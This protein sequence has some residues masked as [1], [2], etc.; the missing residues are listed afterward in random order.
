MAGVLRILRKKHPPQEG[1]LDLWEDADSG[2]PEVEDAEQ[3]L[4]RLKSKA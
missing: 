1:I 3:R 4:A 2:I